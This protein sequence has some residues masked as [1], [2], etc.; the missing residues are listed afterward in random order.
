MAGYLVL[1]G[2]FSELQMGALT[3]QT[4]QAVLTI[5]YLQ[6]ILLIQLQDGLWGSKVIIL[7]T[8]DGGG[9][10]FNEDD[11]NQNTNEYYFI[12]KLPQPIQPYDNNSYQIPEIGFYYTK[13]L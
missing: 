11:R 4:N 10:T 13:S 9:I 3:G 1:K 2:K 12:P 7:H 5:F 8:T 6:F